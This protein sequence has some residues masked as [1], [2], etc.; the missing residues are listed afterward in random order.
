MKEEESYIM[1]KINSFNDFLN[2]NIDDI[3]CRKEDIIES[4]KNMFDE[5][6]IDDFF[7]KL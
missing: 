2:E 1:L 4:F 3:D 7:K 5:D 6:I